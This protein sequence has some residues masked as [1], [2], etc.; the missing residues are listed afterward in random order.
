VSRRWTTTVLRAVTDDANELTISMIRKR[1]T[2]IVGI[3]STRR[4]P[5]RRH[6]SQDWGAM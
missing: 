4:D 3:A 5:S 6:T 2:L 1:T